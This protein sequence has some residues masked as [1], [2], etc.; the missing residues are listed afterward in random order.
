MHREAANRLYK[1]KEDQSN[2]QNDMKAAVERQKQA[3]ERL[4]NIK[5]K[6]AAIQQEKK[7]FTAF[8]EN[9]SE[10]LPI[11]NRMENSVRVS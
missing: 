1:A 4:N 2:S 8:K 5:N 11:L 3:K 7:R 9:V 10:V 6:L